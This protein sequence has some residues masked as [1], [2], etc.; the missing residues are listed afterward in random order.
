M[1]AIH[2]GYELFKKKWGY[3]LNHQ[4]RSARYF[5]LVNRRAGR[6][7]RRWPSK[8]SLAFDAWRFRVYRTLFRYWE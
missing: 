8:F 4:G 6:M 2:E 3:D 1:R 5:E 7:T